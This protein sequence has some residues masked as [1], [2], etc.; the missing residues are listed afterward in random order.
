[1]VVFWLNE[2][3]T[4]TEDKQLA[5]LKRL[6]WCGVCMFANSR[7]ELRSTMTPP[8]LLQTARF[9]SI[10]KPFQHL[11]SDALHQEMNM[12]LRA[13]AQAMAATLRTPDYPI[14]TQLFFPRKHWQ[15]QPTYLVE[16]KHQDVAQSKSYFWVQFHCAGYAMDISTC[17]STSFDR[18]SAHHKNSAEL[19]KAFSLSG[20]LLGNERLAA[21]PKQAIEEDERKAVVTEER[22]E[23]DKP[24]EQ[25]EDA[26][27]EHKQHNNPQ[28][29]KE[30]DDC[31]F[32]T[33]VHRQRNAYHTHK[34]Q[35]IGF[36]L[37][38]LVPGYESPPLV[39]K[40]DSAIP[41]VPSVPSVP[42]VDTLTLQVRVCG[43]MTTAFATRIAITA[44][45]HRTGQFEQVL[46]MEGP[47]LSY[48]PRVVVDV[49][50]GK[51]NTKHFS[52]ADGAHCQ[53][54]YVQ[55]DGSVLFRAEVAPSYF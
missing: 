25:K 35:V 10:L 43:Q 23:A 7:Y 30:D 46:L 19:K 2:H 36:Q 32:V 44:K 37:E 52:S 11:I 3:P 28:S 45:N 24:K 38:S 50:H 41:S 34:T 49:F 6:R 14:K 12:K 42:A 22:R 13:Y 39:D 15:K 5:L 51:Y 16:W 1:M 4:T 20:N 8:F 18:R 48:Q 29:T 9:Y 40:S 55:E 21:K 26:E 53:C 27:K 17:A 31:S 54:P 33:P 47:L